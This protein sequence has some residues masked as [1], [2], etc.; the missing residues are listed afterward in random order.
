MLK[1]KKR[2]I[3]LVNLKSIDFI[4]FVYFNKLDSYRTFSSCTSYSDNSFVEPNDDMIF[5][6]NNYYN[7][8]LLLLTTNK[9]KI[10]LFKDLLIFK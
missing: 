2:N 5:K 10:P 1:L 3:W 4:K 7:C 8:K 9:N 6:L